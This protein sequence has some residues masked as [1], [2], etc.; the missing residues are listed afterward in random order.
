VDRGQDLESQSTRSLLEEARSGN[1]QAVDLL[2]ER[3][4][5]FLRRWARG[6]LPGWARGVADTDDL[7]QDTL[8]RT[9]R[10]LDH[11]EYQREKAFLS[12]LCQGAL[13]RVRDEIR[14]ARRRPVVE[15]TAS[16]LPAREPS[17]IEQVVGAET[18]ARYESARDGLKPADREAAFA[19]IEL[20]LDYREIAELLGKPTP[21]AARMAVTRAL[22]RLARAMGHP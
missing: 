14:S 17:P 2:F 5:P 9:L 18:L 4:L 6:R 7:V 19:R 13:N 20:G 16:Q 10:N 11:F 21:D 12:Y 22:V 1:E 8:L 3:Y 15:D